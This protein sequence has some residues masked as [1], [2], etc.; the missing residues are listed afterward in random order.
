[1]FKLYC[2]HCQPLAVNGVPTH[3]RGCPNL[4]ERWV[5]KRKRH[6]G[7]A[8][9]QPVCIPETERAPSWLRREEPRRD[10]A[11]VERM[12]PDHGYAEGEVPA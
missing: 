3:E 5:F 7:D 9:E 6:L 2:G 12:Q 1:M 8:L 11:E 10:E 4:A